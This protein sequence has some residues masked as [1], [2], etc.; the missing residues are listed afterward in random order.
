MFLKNLIINLRASGPAAVLIAWLL[1]ITALGL[2][3]S[4]TL[5]SIALSGLLT[6]GVALIAALGQNVK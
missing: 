3:G 6:L 5:A 2:F 1:C 4:G